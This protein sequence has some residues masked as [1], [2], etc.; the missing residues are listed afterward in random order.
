MK[1]GLEEGSQHRHNAAKGGESKPIIITTFLVSNP[2]ACHFFLPAAPPSLPFHSIR[3]VLPSLLPLPCYVSEIREVTEKRR[4]KY[5]C[6]AST[7]PKSR[8]CKNKKVNN[9]VYQMCLGTR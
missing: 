7:S 6:L 9:T 2:R 8:I 5:G 4:K 3:F 1:E